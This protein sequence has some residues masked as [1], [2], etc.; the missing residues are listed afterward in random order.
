MANNETFQVATFIEKLPPGLQ[1]FRNY[2]KLKRKEMTLEDLNVRLRIEEENLLA[3]K[4]H[5]AQGANIVESS[6][7]KRKRNSGGASG[8][9]TKTQKNTKKQKFLGS[10]YNYGKTGH[11]VSTCKA[12]KKQNKGKGQ[13]NVVEDDVD[14][15]CVVLSECNMVGNPREWWIDSGATRHVCVVN[16]MFSSY[17]SSHAVEK[18]YMGNSSTTHIEGSK[19]ICMKMTSGKAVTLNNVL[20]V[21]EIR[22]NLVST[23]LL[24]KHGFKVDFVSDKVV[25]SKN[26]IFV[27]KG[28]MC[29]GLFKLNVM[30]INNNDASSSS[31][32]LEST[33]LW[34]ARLG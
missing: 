34:H 19:K 18:L 5:N 33:T 14:D 3:A 25:I 8:S 2:L 17:A 6:S 21:R 10:C 30:T 27:G 7:K 20:H 26:D 16:E 24:V 32:L 31:Y 13:A 1:L 12:P 9:G 4:G 23:A 29:D 22:K 28:Y 11:R 15:F